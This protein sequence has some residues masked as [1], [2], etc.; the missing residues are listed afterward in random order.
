MFGY[1]TVSAEH[2]NSGAL[3]V[4]RCD[5]LRGLNEIPRNA[6]FNERLSLT[7]RGGF[8]RSEFALELKAV[9]PSAYSVTETT[10]T[11]DMENAPN[12]AALIK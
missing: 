9:C 3:N 10:R 11:F 2:S 4:S 6:C 1:E 8:Y 12:Y 7:G 5:W